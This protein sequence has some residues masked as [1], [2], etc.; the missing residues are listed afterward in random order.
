MIKDILHF[1]GLNGPDGIKRK[2]PSVDE[3]WHFLNPA[4]PSDR[5]LINT[6]NDHLVN[7]TRA[8]RAKNKVR[9]AF[10][11]AWLAHA[12][13]DGLTPAHHYPLA[14]K[15]KELWGKAPDKRTSIREKNIVPGDN[16]RNTLSKNWEYWGTNG[17]FTTHHLFEM[18]VA[19]AISTTTFKDIDF[20]RR[21]ISRLKEFGFEKI[22]YD[23]LR[24]IDELKMFDKIA[25]QGWTSNLGKKTKDIL[26]PEIIK[27][28]T[29]AWY[30][31]SMDSMDK[32]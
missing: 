13:T 14:D 26:I 28:V 4:D 18:G 2:S 22:F 7:L 32:Q 10:E 1:E 11:A 19:T 8:L 16:L 12:I 15:I 3:P 5:S 25:V 20:S 30:Q 21:D 6:I 31:A 23:S 24:K 9:A 27:V 29:L 17:V